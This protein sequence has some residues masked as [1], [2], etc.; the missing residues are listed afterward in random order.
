MLE[1]QTT[2]SRQIIAGGMK[3]SSIA[4]GVLDELGEGFAGVRGDFRGKRYAR[5]VFSN[6]LE[7][8]WVVGGGGK[9][10]AENLS[11]ENNSWN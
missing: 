8:S 3:D 4:S 7:V 10:D 2:I 6:V 11:Y 1:Q 9:E 5:R